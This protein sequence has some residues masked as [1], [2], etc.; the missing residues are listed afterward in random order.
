MFEQIM[1]PTRRRAELTES[2]TESPTE[3]ITESVT[4]VPELFETTEMIE[5]DFFDNT[6]ENANPT[7]PSEDELVIPDVIKLIE[8]GYDEKE[9]LI[10]KSVEGTESRE[11]MEQMPDADWSDYEDYDK[12]Y[13]LPKI[14][15]VTEATLELPHEDQYSYSYASYE[16][17]EYYDPDDIVDD[18]LEDYIQVTTKSTTTTLRTTTTSAPAMNTTLDFSFLKEQNGTQ[19][20][21][22]DFLKHPPLNNMKYIWP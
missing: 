17:A 7:P 2:Y 1:K 3:D 22:I 5:I 13:D 15:E 8:F 6:T 10:Q 14:T 18:A 16:D 19:I 9:R 4:G 20:K 11:K 21:N 12:V